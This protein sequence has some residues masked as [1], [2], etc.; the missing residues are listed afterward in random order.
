MSAAQSPPD[1]VARIG[2][3][4]ERSGAAVPPANEFLFGLMLTTSNAVLVSVGAPFFFSTGA[5]GGIK[6]SVAAAVSILAAAPPMA[7]G[8]LMY[9][10]NGGRDQGVRGPASASRVA[11]S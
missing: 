4:A 11:M 7:L 6:W 3:A 8:L 5:G 10:H 2:S 1:I 9:R